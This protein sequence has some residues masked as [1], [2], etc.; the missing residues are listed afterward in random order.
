MS[1]V[2]EYYR[3]QSRENIALLGLVVASMCALGLLAVVPIIQQG[4]VWEVPQ[5]I[6][7]IVKWFPRIVFAVA[8]LA[9]LLFGSAIL[10]H[11]ALRVRWPRY[12]PAWSL[13]VVAL[14]L[15]PLFSL[16]EPHQWPVTRE[17]LSFW[18]PVVAILFVLPG[19]WHFIA[20]WRALRRRERLVVRLQVP[21]VL[22]APLAARSAWE[23][24]LARADQAVPIVS[25]WHGRA[26]LTSSAPKVPSTP[27]SDVEKRPQKLVEGEALIDPYRHF[28]L[29]TSELSPF[30][31]KAADEVS[32]ESVVSRA[33]ALYRLYCEHANQLGEL[34]FVS[35]YSQTRFGARVRN[36]L[37]DWKGEL[38]TASR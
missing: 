35:G 30:R 4:P 38:L 18:S 25:G 36:G 32:E 1:A 29:R 27:A 37:Y 33:L 19:A 14:S 24:L 34:A 15:G 8:T 10:S 16:G 3:R 28:L 9:F 31:S 7:P 2:R 21:Q 6:V 5:E 23:A 13:I 17:R 11:G 26:T 12:L 20:G 22:P